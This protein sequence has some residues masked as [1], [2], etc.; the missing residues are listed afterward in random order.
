MAQHHKYSIE[1]VEKLL[2]YERDLYF[3]MLIEF[4]E[5]QREKER[6]S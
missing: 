3:E 2:P 5:S 4:I 6:A 1:D